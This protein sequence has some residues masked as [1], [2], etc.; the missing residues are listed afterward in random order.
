MDILG[1][2]LWLRLT[3]SKLQLIEYKFVVQRR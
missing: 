3:S 1:T 2:L